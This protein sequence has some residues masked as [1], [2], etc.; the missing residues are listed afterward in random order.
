M[1]PIFIFHS[2]TEQSK[3]FLSFSNYTTDYIHFLC[4]H[5][6]PV[7][8][9][10][11]LFFRLLLWS[12]RVS[13]YNKVSEDIIFCVKPRHATQF[14]WASIYD[15]LWPAPKV[16]ADWSPPHILMNANTCL[17][18]V[19][20]NALNTCHSWIMMSRLKPP[21]VP[22]VLSHSLHTSAHTTQILPPVG[23]L[24]A[25]AN[26]FLAVCAG[27]RWTLNSR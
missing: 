8:R 25:K 2:V 10:Q 19:Y 9:P 17:C 15:S 6:Q 21:N 26:G 14:T 16:R 18:D 1:R 11:S 13:G 7:R 4:D 23:H 27:D 24:S 12:Y 5:F 22:E 3:P 20:T